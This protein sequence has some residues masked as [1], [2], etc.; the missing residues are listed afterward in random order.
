MTEEKPAKDESVVLL[1]TSK[2]P[3]YWK[4]VP[5][6]LAR[7]AGAS[8]HFRYRSKWIKDA[9]QEHSELRQKKGYVVHLDGADDKFEYIPIREVL[10]FDTQ[11]FGEHL[12]VDFVLKDLVRYAPRTQDGKSQHA[13]RIS[14]AIRAAGKREG[15]T[16]DFIVTCN[17]KQL[18]TDSGLQNWTQIVH[19]LARFP[20]FNRPKPTVFLV[21]EWRQ[22]TKT[23]SRPFR[24]SS[25]GV[26]IQSPAAY[27]SEGRPEFRGGRHYWLHLIEYTPSEDASGN[28][29]GIDRAKFPIT[30]KLETDESIIK[31]SVKETVIRGMYDDAYLSIRCEPVPRTTYGFVQLAS[32]SEY[33]NVPSLR[34]YEVKVLRAAKLW[35]STISSGVLFAA[36]AWVPALL[37]L[38]RSWGV[39]VDPGLASILT[40]L[41]LAAAGVLIVFVSAWASGK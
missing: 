35:A 2:H 13:V 24:K 32:D 16:G 37:N 22:R 36:G 38:L 10:I 41:S 25:D 39:G 27:D 17:M 29:T 23:V 3:P 26:S 9:F 8:F 40:S 30:L 11:N 14:E 18:E 28:E 15:F 20:T 6:I 7:E 5:E 12:R 19:E 1:I 33:F 4:D 31:P 34:F 21:A